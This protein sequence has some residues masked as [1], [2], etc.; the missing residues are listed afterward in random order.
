MDIPG[1]CAMYLYRNKVSQHI[2][3]MFLKCIREVELQHEK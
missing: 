2:D 3:M 1:S